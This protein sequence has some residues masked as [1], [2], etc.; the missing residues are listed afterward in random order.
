MAVRRTKFAGNVFDELI[1]QSLEAVIDKPDPILDL[2][3]I[4]ERFARAMALKAARSE[5]DNV[6][7]GVLQSL[8][9]VERPNCAAMLHADSEKIA[10]GRAC[11]TRGPIQ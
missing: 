4:P 7:S 11:F 10:D 6:I 2:R 3:L 8:S 1:L 9:L 5:L